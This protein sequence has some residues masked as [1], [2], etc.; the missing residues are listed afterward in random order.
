[1]KQETGKKNKWLLPVILAAVLLLIGGAVAAIFLLQPQQA[2]QEQ[3]QPAAA[4][5]LY[6]NL[7]REQTLDPETGMSLREKNDQGQFVIR[8]LKDGKIEELQIADKLLV[9]YIDSM[10]VMGLI[11]DDSGVVV[12][13][14]P[15]K[16]AAAEIA[17]NF[18]VMKQEGGRLTINSS[19][20]ANGVNLQLDLTNATIY[21]VSVDSA[22][23][24]APATCN[25]LDEV[26]VYGD[27]DGNTTHVFIVTRSI[28]AGV[29]LRVKQMYSST[30]RST[31]R[32]PDENGVYTIE[33]AHKGEIVS[34]K[35]KDKTLVTNID[36]ASAPQ[37]IMGLIFDEE[38]YITETVLTAQAIRGKLL[39]DNY[40]IMSM[41]GDV[42][43]L[44]KKLYN[45]KDIGRQATV[46]LTEDT[47]IYFAEDECEADHMGQKADSLQVGDRVFAY[48]DMDNRAKLIYI[49]RRMQDYEIYYNVSQKYDSTKGETTREKVNGYY[50]FE[51][52]G[53]GK[54]WELK[55][56]DKKVANFI[57]S[58][59]AKTMGIKRSG[60]TIEA[61]CHMNCVV[62][63]RQPGEGRFVTNIASNIVTIFSSA[64]TSSGNYILSPNAQILD[65]TGDYGIKP[66]AQIKELRDGDRLSFWIDVDG[67]LGAASVTQRYYSNT[68]LYYNLGRTYNAT[69]QET[70]RV[71]DAEGYYV[72]EMLCEDK[73]VTVKTKDKAMASYIDKDS[74]R[75]VALRVNKEGIVKEAH[76]N[77][78]AIKYGRRNMSSVYYNGTN[79][80]GTINY[81]Y[82]G[83]DGKR[84]DTASTYKFASDCKYYNYSTTFVSHQGEKT[85]LQKGDQIQAFSSYENKEVK[86]IFIKA[87][88]FDS[89]LYYTVS[90]KYN[91]TTLET[92][93]VPAEDGY[94]Y[95]DLLVDG[96]VKTFK[97][98]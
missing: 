46:T 13:A 4:T 40:T 65:V 29:Y 14:V 36:K 88:E 12:D 15:A 90:Q 63:N 74:S 18:F 56:K 41:D 3:E 2:P 49:S 26:M 35:C 7:D 27:A 97:T 92:T 78:S 61:A 72:F 87:R 43:E 84:I 57:D 51:M 86:V 52:I 73:A 83:E 69:L 32:V 70:K 59:S 8:F 9:N 17:K 48:T 81:Y 45:A 94:Y 95:T 23:P 66:G 42:L 53:E 39:A 16:D 64:F 79:S 85:K 10:P 5:G 24:T 37:N 55:T 11:F 19:I 31:S 96:Q 20:A 25:T 89:K 58:L 75:Y 38:G 62:G 50:V 68:K 54:R 91:S 82:F 67:N 77:V 34:L 22:D 28:E 76:K 30:L 93:R 44:E 98:K 71:P 6:W 33:F 47:E 60:S 80:D 1:M 21:D